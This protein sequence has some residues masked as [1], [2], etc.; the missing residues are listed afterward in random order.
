MRP[1]DTS[2]AAAIAAVTDDM[3]RQL[4]TLTFSAPVTH[5]Y[6]PLIYARQGFD[7]YIARF[8]A[9]PKTIIL[10]GM[11]PGPYGMVQT[12]VPFGDVE[13]VK[14]WLGIRAVVATPDCPHP[15]RPV[16]G[17]SCDRAEISGRRLWGW[18]R[19]RFKRPEAFLERF[20][21]LNYCPLAFMEASG[22]NRTPDRL[23]SDEKRALFDICDRALQRSIDIYRPRWVVGVGRFAEKRAEAALD[24]VAASIGGICHPSPANPKANRGW[25]T[26]VEEELAAMGIDLPE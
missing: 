11:N 14:G 10:L 19:Q 12:G 17:F 3:V 18:A 2:L 4:G 15:K 13:M 8:G 7:S 6:N 9:S 26:V 16:A 23:R 24:G 1:C 5:V 22:R 25:T 20:L 21:V